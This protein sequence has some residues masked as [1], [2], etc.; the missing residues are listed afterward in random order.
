MREP[1]SSAPTPIGRRKW[2]ALAAVAIASGGAY[3]LVRKPFP[4][5]QTPEGFQMSLFGFPSVAGGKGNDVVEHWAN[6]YGVLKSAPHPDAAVKYLKYITSLEIGKKISEAGTPVPLV[7]APIPPALEN[8]YAILKSMKQMP[9]RAGLNTEAANY[10][11][12]VFNPCDD[13]FF[14]MQLTPEQFISCLQTEG[15][16]FWAT[17]Q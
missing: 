4:S 10:M 5:E 8:Q 17:T 3:F 7:G 15:K 9:A 14:Q 1:V 2:L 12:K 16:T 6:V 13:K 11:E